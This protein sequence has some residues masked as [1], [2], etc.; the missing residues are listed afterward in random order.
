MNEFINTFI[1]NSV[2]CKQM[3]QSDSVNNLFE[4]EYMKDNTYGLVHYFLLYLTTL[5]IVY[6]II[7]RIT[8]LRKM[9][10]IKKSYGSVEL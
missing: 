1:K 10:K 6:T 5:E 4:L 7:R 3:Q 2:I 8:K 9:E